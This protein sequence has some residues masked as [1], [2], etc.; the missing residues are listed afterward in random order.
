[1][2]RKRY[3]CGCLC[4]VRRANFTT[5]QKGRVWPDTFS[6]SFLRYASWFSPQPHDKILS[7]YDGMG[8]LEMRKTYRNVLKHRFQINLV[9][10]RM[11][12]GLTQAQMAERLAMDERSYIDL[13]HGKSCCSAVTL[14]LYLVYVCCDVAEF[15]EELRDAFESEC[16]QAA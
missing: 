2:K 15:L 6:F 7:K 13:D 9:R 4:A 14:A 11:T 12:I 16:N 3:I 5:R 10:T 8:V 1:M